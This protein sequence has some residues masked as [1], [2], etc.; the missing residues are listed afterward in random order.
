[1]LSSVLRQPCLQR[2]VN[3]NHHLTTSIRSY[4]SRAHPRPPLPPLSV[5]SALEA[6]I[7]DVEKRQNRR[8]RKRIRNAKLKSEDPESLETKHFDETMELALNLNL[9]PRKPGQSL[10]GSISL[11]NGTG[12]SLSVMVLTSNTEL[13]ERAREAGAAYVGGD[14]LVDE[15]VNGKVPVDNLA[16]TLGM[17]DIKSVNKA[18]RLLGPR[19]LMP[20]TK[21]GTQFE[22]EEALLDALRDTIQGKNAAFRTEKAGIIHM[23][24][25]KASFGV[26]KLLENIRAVMERVWEIQPESYGKVKKG[27]KKASKHAKYMLGATLSSTQGKGVKVDLRTIDPQSVFFLKPLE[28]DVSTEPKAALAA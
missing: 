2:L 26:D 24:I 19:G 27:K 12:K 7:D 8:Q 13:Q 18:A 16:R 1:M 11:P 21:A 10:R 4:I 6:V 3:P 14:E 5:G 25:G 15:I 9:D 20:T 28:D 17:T 22:D 23:P